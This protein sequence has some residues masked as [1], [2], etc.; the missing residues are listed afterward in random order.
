MRKISIIYTG[1][2][3]G[4]QRFSNS[5]VIKSN[6]LKKFSEILANKMPDWASSLRYEIVSPFR[7]L[8][9]NFEPNDW[10]VLANSIQD[11][12]GGGAEALFI[13]H[14]TDTLMYSAAAVSMMF[15]NP[16]IPIVFTGSND[17]IEDK[18]TDA[19]QNL[20]HALWLANEV[21]L[22]KVLVSFSGTPDG[23]SLVL[24]GVNLS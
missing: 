13:A 11:A 23:E 24:S 16:P 3:I 17:P 18:D 22:K 7:K 5:V 14:G 2:T 8:S 9:E 6:T 15:Q 10:V 21:T 4:G 12:I 19:I 20:S 1:G